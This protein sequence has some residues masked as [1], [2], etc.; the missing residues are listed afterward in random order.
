MDD[1]AKIRQL[2]STGQRSKREIGR[3]VG[4]SRGTVDRALETD[5]V[6]KYQRASTG[7]SF[8]AFAAQVRVL[9]AVTPTMP[10]SVLAERVGWSGS[11]SVL[12]D[13]VAVIRPEYVPPDPADRLVHEPGKQVQCDL[14]FPREPLPLGRGQGGAAEQ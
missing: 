14:W 4:V 8:D 10:A 5:R 2:F 11:A 3:L 6:P 1:W 9:L 7:S 12:R 13:K